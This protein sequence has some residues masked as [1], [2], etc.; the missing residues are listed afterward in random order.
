METNM[1]V[2]QIIEVSN[3]TGERRL[4]SVISLHKRLTALGQSSLV[5]L[6]VTKGQELELKHSYFRPFN[7]RLD[8]AA[9]PGDEL[10]KLGS[11]F[12]ANIKQAQPNGS[13]GF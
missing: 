5:T 4:H 9:R 12:P 7:N 1:Q 13:W 10:T 2:K 8:S 3:H 11:I 6:A